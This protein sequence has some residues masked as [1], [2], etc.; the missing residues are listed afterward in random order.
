MNEKVINELISV[1]KEESQNN[2]IKNE[3]L[4]EIEEANDKSLLL[5]LISLRQIIA[6]NDK[7][8]SI[9]VI[10]SLMEVLKLKIF[11][12]KSKNNYWK[13]LK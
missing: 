10:D 3:Q 7:E 6:N 2:Y 8:F 11:N 4:K 12:L 5:I 13:Y 1:L 9:S